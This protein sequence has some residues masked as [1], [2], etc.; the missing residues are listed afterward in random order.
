M[1]PPSRAL[2]VSPVWAIAALALGGFAIGTTEFATMGV[3]PQI[4]DGVGVSVPKAGH[5]ISAYALGVVVG[6]PILAFFAASLPRKA[7]LLAFMGIYALFNAASAIAGSYGML[8]V[9][10]FLAGLPHGAYFG[11]A[12]LVAA[13]L[14]RPEL[15]GRAVA[16]VMMG[17]SIANVVGVPAAT[18][19]GQQTGWRAT[20]LA[21]ASLALITVILV[22]LV[23]PHQPGD[24]HATGRAEARVFFS[25]AQ[26]WLTL[27]AGAVGFGGLFCVYSYI[28]KTVTNVAGLGEDVVPLFTLAFG[29]G[30]VAGTWIGGE[31]ARWSVFRS[32][33]IGCVGAGLSLLGF[34]WAAPHGWLLWPVTFL[35]TAIGSVLVINLQVRLMDVAGNAVTLGAAMNHAA[36]NIANALGAYLGG[37]VIDAGHGYRSPALVGVALSVVGLVI[38]LWSATLHRRTALTPTFVGET[39]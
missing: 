18:W 9:A 37:V 34:W 3:L 13:S 38:L 15:K 27:A 30:M 16:G 32:L 17:L 26:V 8:V 33:L 5:V 31:L 1:T 29:L 19:L 12:S 35:V 22:T 20:Y 39:L 6:V 28:A 11:V 4:A 14:V 10:R 2:A 7:L 25:N 24:A 36:L 21:C 23:V